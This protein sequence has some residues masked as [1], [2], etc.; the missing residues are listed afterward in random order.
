MHPKMFK[1]VQE[2]FK[3]VQALFLQIKVPYCGGYCAGADM[4]KRS[5]AAATY[6][7]K[8]AGKHAYWVVFTGV[9]ECVF[10][11]ITPFAE[12]VATVL[13]W[14]KWWKSLITRA[15]R[16]ATRKRFLSVLQIMAM[17]APPLIQGPRIPLPGLSWTRDPGARPGRPQGTLS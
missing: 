7:N 15:R 2:M 5:P 9:F 6:I 13:K 11:W 12:I 3:N 16:R 4:F 1:N 17:V 10:F 8:R 14:K